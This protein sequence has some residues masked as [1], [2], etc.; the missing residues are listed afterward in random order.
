VGWSVPGKKPGRQPT[1]TL[2]LDEAARAVAYYEKTK[3]ITDPK[4]KPVQIAIKAEA[5][6]VC[7]R[8]YSHEVTIHWSVTEGQRP[9]SI[10]AEIIYPDKHIENVE[11]RTNEGS[12]PF[13]TDYPGGGEI[14]VKAIADDSTKQNASAEATVQLKPCRK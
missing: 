7:Q 8:G 2:K 10:R 11:L 9:V 14:R 4:A 6:D 3:S 13:P 12:R 5:R 1:I